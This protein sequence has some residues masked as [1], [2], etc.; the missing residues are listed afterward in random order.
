MQFANYAT[1]VSAGRQGLVAFVDP[2]GN[3]FYWGQDRGLHYLDSGVKKITMGFDQTGNPVID[4][5]FTNG[6]LWDWRQAY[7]WN[8]IDSS[9]TDVSKAQAGV[10][11]DVESLGYAIQFDPWLG[12]QLL[13]TDIQQVA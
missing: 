8:Q 7:G 2:W 13:A 12:N 9:V 11:N 4:E 6:N 5:L 10:V 1:Q 3:S